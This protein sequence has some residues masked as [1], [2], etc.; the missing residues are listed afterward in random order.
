MNTTDVTGYFLGATEWSTNLP[1]QQI[2]NPCH[3]KCTTRQDFW[4]GHTFDNHDLITE[5]STG[6]HEYD[7]EMNFSDFQILTPDSAIPGRLPKAVIGDSP[8]STSYNQSTV[9]DDQNDVDQ[10]QDA[11]LPSPESP[12]TVTKD[13]PQNASQDA[14]DDTEDCIRALSELSLSPN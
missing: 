3:S 4:N 1:E 7:T 5:L 9:S 6:F 10:T 13:K 11:V 8:S 14:A 12:I 2:L